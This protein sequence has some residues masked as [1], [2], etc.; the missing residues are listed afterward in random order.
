MELGSLARAP[1]GGQSNNMRY[2]Q[3]GMG[4]S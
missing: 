3:M 1:H 2:M 4:K